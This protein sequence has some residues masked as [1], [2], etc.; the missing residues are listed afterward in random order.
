[1]LESLRTSLPETEIALR[2]GL[3]ALLAAAIGI[4]RERLD[5]SAGLRTHM[6]TASA[7]ALFTILTFEI[8][9]RL[10]A[11]PERAN[12]DPIRIIEAVTAGVAFLAGGAIIRGREGVQGLTTGA[13]MWLA[14][15]IGV[16]SGAGF[17]SIAVMATAL[18][19]F[20]LVIVRWLERKPT[21]GSDP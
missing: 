2:L 11:M 21:D 20:I 14:G 6:L 3:A 13:G 17:Y 1:M 5:R 8:H 12:T 19:V 18:A 15:A 9:A 16:A 7:A 4:D 10:M